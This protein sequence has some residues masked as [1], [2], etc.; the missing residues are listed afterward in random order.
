MAARCTVADRG[1]QKC[2][3]RYT[4]S[5]VA[6]CRALPAF[7]RLPLADR[8]LVALSHQLIALSVR[9]EGN[10]EWLLSQRLR[11]KRFPLGTVAYR[12]PSSNGAADRQWLDRQAIGWYLPRGTRPMQTATQTSCQLRCRTS[13]SERP[14]AQWTVNAKLLTQGDY[15][16]HCVRGSDDNA[17][18][19]GDSA[20]IVEAIAAATY[21]WPHLMKRY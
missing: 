20:A 10:I 14:V 17:F 7:E 13:P 16:I 2:S 8:L 19:R 4:F 18:R 12:M 5:F 9:P 1:R 21:R 15:L 3:M 6:V 11:D